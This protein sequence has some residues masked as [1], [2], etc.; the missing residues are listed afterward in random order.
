MYMYLLGNLVWTDE[1]MTDIHM[2]EQKALGH[3]KN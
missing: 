1:Y 3:F 2:A